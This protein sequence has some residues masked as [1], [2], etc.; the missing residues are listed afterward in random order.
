MRNSQIVPS[1]RAGHRPGT[2]ADRGCRSPASIS[3]LESSK[4]VAGMGEHKL[5]VSML[6]MATGVY[7]HFLRVR[8]DSEMTYLWLCH[9]GPAEMSIF[10]G[11]GSRKDPSTNLIAAIG[12]KPHAAHRAKIF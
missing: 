2:H 4:K 9:S 5:Q 6:S 12:R 11:S 8:E 10:I 7:N 1:S 3:K